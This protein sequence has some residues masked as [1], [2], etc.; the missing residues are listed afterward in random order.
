MG[1]NGAEEGELVSVD[2]IGVPLSMRQQGWSYHTLR[3][4]FRADESDNGLL[5]WRASAAPS[6]SYVRSWLV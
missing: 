2:P 5:T 4:W 1:V 6:T 3:C